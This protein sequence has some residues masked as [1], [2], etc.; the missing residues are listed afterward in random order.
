MDLMSL[1]TYSFITTYTPGPNPIMAMSN[2][3]AYGFKKTIPF[4]LGI[5]PGFFIVLLLC[6]SSS[7]LINVILPRISIVMRFL[8]AGYMLYLAW[9]SLSRTGIDEV[10][11]T[12]LG[13]KD[14]FLLQFINVKT[15]FYG[16][17]G[18]TYVMNHLTNPKNIFIVT[19][20]LATIPMTS[21]ITWAALGT[22]FKK[23]FNKHEKLVNLII[24]LLLV[25][26][27]YKIIK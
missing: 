12:G 25:Y 13:F 21:Y 4:L 6:V 2:S 5:F 10:K 9:K 23:Y 3:S 7:S 1:A 24:S 20:V 18:A 17:T 22:I 8:G 16:L 19:L 11:T 26:A 15:F 14:G 27:A